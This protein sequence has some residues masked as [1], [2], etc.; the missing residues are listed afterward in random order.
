[1]KQITQQIYAWS[2]YDPRRRLD[3]NGHFLQADAGRPGVLIDPVPLQPGDREQIMA[4]GGVDAVLLCQ[5]DRAAESAWCHE[6][7]G[8]PIWV[9]EVQAG[10]AQNA[11]RAAPPGA[12][13]FGERDDLPGELVAMPVSG[14]G[15]RGERAFYHPASASLFVGE[16]VVGSPAGQLSLFAAEQSEQA[17]QVAVRGLRALLALP[18]E[19]LLV[20]AGYPLLREPAAALQ[21][22][23]YRHDPAAFLL[24][25][26]ELSWGLA[27]LVGSKYHFRAAECSRLLGLRAIDFDLKEVASGRQAVPLH[28]HDAEEEVFVIISGSG[29]VLTE[30]GS[31][32]VAAGDVLGFPPRYQIAHAIRNTGEPPLRYLAFSAAAEEVEMVDYPT[33]GARLERAGYGKRRRFFLPERLDVP[34]FENEPVD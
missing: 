4:F 10:A 13:P 33:S 31:F 6:L 20:G 12:R 27:R 18:A 14:S 34:Y 19:R 15:S 26:A 7:F 28:R 23:I 29:E 3:R 22:L 17:H 24:R 21:D 1:M 30:R 8:C 11:L 2:Q 32:A 5:G 25:P 9:P 16:A